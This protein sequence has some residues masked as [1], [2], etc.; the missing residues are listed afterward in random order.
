VSAG[1]SYWNNSQH[2]IVFEHSAAP[3]GPPESIW[4]VNFR[5]TDPGNPLHDPEA[6]G[7]GT[8]TQ[9]PLADVYDAF[10][11]YKFVWIPG[12]IKFYIDNALITEHTSNVPVVPGFFQMSYFGRNFINWGGLA[13][14]GT[15]YFFV[16]RAAY[17]P[18]P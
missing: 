18:L 7:N 15:R 4:F 13:T 14:A 6:A 12:S 11:H 8:V 2:E 1:F 3:A 10:H 16:D 9:H 5:N 17:T